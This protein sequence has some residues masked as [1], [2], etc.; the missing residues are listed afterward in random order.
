MNIL[1]KF[2]EASDADP[3]SQSFTKTPSELSQYISNLYTKELEINRCTPIVLEFQTLLKNDENGACYTFKIE[4]TQ[5][6]M[7]KLLVELYLSSAI[8]WIPKYVFVPKKGLKIK[9][10]SD[11]TVYTIAHCDPYSFIST[12]CSSSGEIIDLHESKLKK[13][14]IL[15]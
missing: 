4:G 10:N 7:E 8:S 9:K 13:E 11:G 15:A 3:V 14:F 5:E 2:Y 6:E 12:I 1:E